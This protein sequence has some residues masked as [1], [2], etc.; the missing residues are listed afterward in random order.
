[1]AEGG[2]N[3][4]TVRP[5]LARALTFG[6]A[7]ASV[8]VA[9]LLELLFA[10]YRLPHAFTAFALSAIAISFWYGGTKPGIVAMLLAIMIR[11]YLFD[12]EIATL[13][14]VLCNKKDPRFSS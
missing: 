14:R 4:R 1:M 12:A 10:H 3:K 6:W 5:V 8:M 7:I 13:S 11:S 9:L 2:I